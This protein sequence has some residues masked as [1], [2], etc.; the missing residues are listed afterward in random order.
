VPVTVQPLACLQ[1]LRREQSS[2]RRQSSASALQA[3]TCKRT[4]APPGIRSPCGQLPPSGAT[5]RQKELLSSPC[6]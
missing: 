3:H 1:V 2:Q 6:G 4:I 5:T